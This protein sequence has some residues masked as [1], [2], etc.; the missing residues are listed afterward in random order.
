M[1]AESWVAWTASFLALVCR[2]AAARPLFAEST[3][4]VELVPSKFNS[5]VLSSKLAW[6]IDFY[7]DWCPHCRH[8]APVWEHVAGMFKD[9]HRVSFGALNCADHGGFCTDVRVGVY[10][11]M[12][13]Y[14]FP[15]L[16]GSNM[17]RGADFHEGEYKE[18]EQD[19]LVKL[20]KAKIALLGPLRN[21][22]ESTNTGKASF[23]RSGKGVF[24]SRNAQEA[25]AGFSSQSA[26]VAD[27]ELARD[28]CEAFCLGDSRCWGC[29]VFCET[30][31]CQWNAVAACGEQMAWSGRIAG[32]VTRKA[33][34][35]SSAAPAAS[36]PAPADPEASAGAAAL[37]HID[38]EVALAY[39]LRQGFTVAAAGSG[40]AT[41][42]QPA[43]LQG[44][45]L[46]EL[47]RWLGFLAAVLPSLRARR[48]LH[49]LADVARSAQRRSGMLERSRW[50]EALS[51]RVIDQ[52]PVH[53]GEDPTPYWR[54]CGTY[55]CGLWMLFHVVTVATAEGRSSLGS[56]AAL[57]GGGQ[58]RPSPA[59]ALTRIRGFVAYF[60]GCADC[61]GH[62][63]RAFD[64]CDWGRCTLEPW[65]GVGAALWLWQ[66][67]NAVTER[68]AA[69]Q[70]RPPPPP[71][72]RRELCGP[73]W[74]P[75]PE[76]A[77]SWEPAAVYGYLIASYWQ[78][79]GPPKAEG[80]DGG[81]LPRF[82]Q[83]YG[84]SLT[85]L[86]G[87]GVLAAAGAAALGLAWRSSQRRSHDYTC[88]PM[89]SVDFLPSRESDSDEGPCCWNNEEQNCE[90]QR[91]APN[92]REEN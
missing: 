82:L 31:A 49:A 50:L 77:R 15:G 4:V 51:S 23:V 19:G 65:D 67:H 25:L 46:E 26:S 5:T 57:S 60:F 80:E 35:D 10:P 66:V 72:P 33:A 36:A 68:V 27:L 22:S 56:N 81:A 73:C 54:L 87:P 32:D 37:R 8:F 91:F 7:A 12:R 39:A 2:M 83:L 78:G 48:S 76:G 13:A 58:L 20:L 17:V 63:V 6:V 41:T 1:N 14:H 71:W 44:E 69:E 59:D 16:N 11:T 43:A 84:Y 86:A 34:R 9:E 74:G 28:S 89:L 85:M 70:G 79:Q 42:D 90:N 53:A 24:C 52:V 30:E 40:N 47:V 38:A 29:S 18:L 88:M 21:A 55:T 61:V 45:A 62:F 3:T 92:G 75:G 64:G